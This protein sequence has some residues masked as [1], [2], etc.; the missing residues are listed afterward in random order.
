[1]GRSYGLSAHTR[2]LAGRRHV[3]LHINVLELK[4]VLLAIRAILPHLTGHVVAVRSDN[5]TA[6]SYINKQGGTV[7]RTLCKLALDIWTL[8][9]QRNIF[10]V[11]T[12]VPGVQNVLADALSR[13][14]I[15]TH[16]WSIKLKYLHPIFRA[17]G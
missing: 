7:S 3:L 1:M 12:H 15:T 17:W 2:P 16:E 5:T 6:V 10:L 14:H 13:D 11:A 8:C 4:A 9:I